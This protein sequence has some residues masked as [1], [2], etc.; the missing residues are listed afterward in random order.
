MDG[1]T[2]FTACTSP[3]SYSSLRQGSHTF[4]VRAINTAGNPD[5]YPA[6]R[7]WF[8]DTVVPKGTI[9]INGKDTSTKSQSVTLYLSA[10]D[11]SST[12]GPSTASGLASM[13]FSNTN[14]TTSTWSD[15]FPYSGTYDS[16]PLSNGAGTKT[17]YVQFKDRAENIS[18]TAYDRIKYIP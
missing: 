5:P 6:S 13:R 4:W 1:A 17:V 10:S 8:V 12:S 14:T 16:W 9:A 15:W 7:N 2:S 3:K 18:A 11:P